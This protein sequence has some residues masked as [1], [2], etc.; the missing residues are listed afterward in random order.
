MMKRQFLPLPPSLN[1]RG[2]PLPAATARLPTPGIGA[3]DGR[4]FLPEAAKQIPDPSSSEA[5]SLPATR[6]AMGR[7]DAIWQSVLWFF[8]EGYALYSASVHWVATRAVAAVANEVDARQR[9]KRAR[10][11]RQNPAS[12]ASPAARAEIT[13]L[14]REGAA[15][16]TAFETRTPSTRDDLAAP[17][18]EVD[19]YRS[20]HPGWPAVI[21][22]WRNTTTGCCEIWK[23]PIDPGS[24]RS[25][26]MAGTTDPAGRK[27]VDVAPALQGLRPLYS[28]E[29][30]DFKKFL[31]ARHKRAQM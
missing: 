30:Y 27:M 17:V 2:G 1:R 20:V 18:R 25:S 12:F 3:H 21:W 4:G 28:R 29:L 31:C 8:F 11:E 19:R 23:F 15:D 10:S 6:P 22:S 5:K 13:M 26:D 24:N 9:Q 16:R 7:A 14:E